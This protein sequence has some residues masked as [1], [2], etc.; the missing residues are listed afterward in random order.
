MLLFIRQNDRLTKLK[1]FRDACPVKLDVHL[2][3]AAGTDS[4]MVDRIFETFD[5]FGFDKILLTKLDETDFFGA[6]IEHA[7]KFNRPFSFLMDDPEVR[8]NIMD[9]RPDDL[10]RMLLD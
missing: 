1:E 5:S 9:A 7:D 6:V 10:A 3:V 8:G 2:T 4:R